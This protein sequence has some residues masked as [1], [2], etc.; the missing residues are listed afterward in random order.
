M[1]IRH[2]LCTATLVLAFAGNG[3]AETYTLDSK[4]T[5]PSFE[6]SHIGFSTQRG[7][8]DLTSGTVKLDARNET[9]SIHV[10]IDANSIDT[11]L[12]ELEAKLRDADFFNTAKFPFITFDSNKIKFTGDKPIAAE[13]TLTLLGISKPVLLT[14]EHFRCGV[15]PVSRRNVCGADASGLIK[16]SDFG[17]KALLPMVADEV[18]LIIQVEAFLN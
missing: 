17:M 13:G 14:I 6:I 10:N 5:F 12:P 1:T 2:T 3:M 11:G 7:R 16:R 18:R 9:G 15:H 8:F 4:H